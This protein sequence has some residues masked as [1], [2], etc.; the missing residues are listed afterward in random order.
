SPD[1]QPAIA[2]AE[3]I[4]GKKLQRGIWEQIRLDFAINESPDS[5]V[6]R[7]QERAVVVFSQP[8]DAVRLV[9]HR[10]ELWRT[11]FPSPQPV[12]DSR[13]EIVLAVLIQ[14]KHSVAKSTVLAV[15]TDAAILNR[16]ELPRRGKRER[17]SPYR[18]FTIFYELVNFQSG[19]LR[20]LGQ[21][22]VL[23]T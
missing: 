23:P 6:R 9:W 8:L 13:P 15:A 16:T 19:K 22:A 1:P 17:A 12:L 18:A 14:T 21:L 5:A 20:V 4:Q 7:N 3:Q 2:I 11:R 10:I